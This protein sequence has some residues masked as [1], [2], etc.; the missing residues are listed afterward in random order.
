MI[1]GR[2]RNRNGRHTPSPRPVALVTATHP[3]RHHRPAAHPMEQP[4]NPSQH[5]HRITNATLH[6]LPAILNPDQDRY[7]DTAAPET[8]DATDSPAAVG[9]LTQPP[10]DS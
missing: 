3:P 1:Y 2:R 5:P 4:G 8:A 7:H 9:P 6:A 10:R